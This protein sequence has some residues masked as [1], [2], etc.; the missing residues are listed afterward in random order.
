MSYGT[1][2]TILITCLLIG[3]TSTTHQAPYPRRLEI[4]GNSAPRNFITTIEQPSLYDLILAVQ[5]LLAPATRPLRTDADASSPSTQPAAAPPELAAAA[6]FD[7]QELLTTPQG[8]VGELLL[9]SG[10]FVETQPLQ[11]VSTPPHL[12][13]I[14]LWSTLLIERKSRQPVQILTLNRPSDT[15]RLA[16]IGAAGYFYMVRRDQA[17]K[18]GASGEKAVIRVPVLIGWLW[19]EPPTPMPH[20]SRFTYFILP[21]VLA[22]IFIVFIFVAMAGRQRTDWRSRRQQRQRRTYRSWSDNDHNEQQNS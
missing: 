14:A 20:R 17:R 12:K 13:G 15:P 19:D 16:N 4:P 2:V 9:L 18:A 7:R 3:E 6:P 21:A 8:L 1:Y 10:K 22:G 5:P 11:L